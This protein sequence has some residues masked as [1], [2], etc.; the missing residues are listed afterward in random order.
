MGAETNDRRL[1]S[2]LIQLFCTALLHGSVAAQSPPGRLQSNTSAQIEVLVTS[3]ADGIYGESIQ[4]LPLINRSAIEMLA[5]SRRDIFTMSNPD[6][7]AATRW[8]YRMHVRPQDKED[9]IVAL[10]SLQGES[11]DVSTK[12]LAWGTGEIEKI[13]V[14][15]DQPMTSILLQPLPLGVLEIVTKIAAVVPPPGFTKNHIAVLTTD[16]FFRS[17]DDGQTWGTVDDNGLSGATKY[18][19]AL[20]FPATYILAHS[21]GLSLR[22]VQG[23]SWSNLPYFLGRAQK[24]VY[25]DRL[26]RIFVPDGQRLLSS[27]NNAAS[28]SVLDSGKAWIP[29]LKVF[30]DDSYKNIYGS[31]GFSCWEFPGGTGPA[32]HVDLQLKTKFWDEHPTDQ[33]INS[34]GGDNHVYAGTRFGGYR[35]RPDTSWENLTQGIKSLTINGFIQLRSGK[36]VVS[37]NLGLSS[38]LSK[39]DSVFLHA[40]PAKYLADMPV[41]TDKDDRIYT[42]GLRWDPSLSNSLRLNYT[43][44]DAGVTFNPDTAGLAAMGNGTAPY[45]SVTSNGTQWY[46]GYGFNS[47][48]YSK[49]SGNSWKTDI[50]GIGLRPSFRP[51]SLG[52]AGDR[53]YFAASDAVTGKGLVWSRSTFESLWAED[54]LGLGQGNVYSFTSMRNGLAL[55]GTFNAGLWRYRYGS[56]KRTSQGGSN[57]AAATLGSWKKLPSPPGLENACVF[58]V[59]V[60]SSGAIIA[61]FTVYTG[62]GFVARGV[63]ATQDTGITWTNAVLDSIGVRQLVSYGTTT[64]VST[65][66]RGLWVIER[67][68]ATSASTSAAQPL[69]FSLVQNYPNPF[70]ASTVI[71]YHVPGTRVAL[72]RLTVYDLL[73]R[74]VKTLVNETK[75]PGAYTVQFDASGLTSGAYFYRLQSGGAVQMKKALLI[76]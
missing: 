42:L 4:S 69:E 36:Q 25:V 16:R 68:T 52:S 35:L 38:R 56:F 15:R 5:A 19:V 74:E 39:V 30:G 47:L 24:Q 13:E 72:V 37:N 76:K 20:H 40:W 27:T 71:G 29:D 64:Y 14:I 9:R 41:F 50:D 44:N 43:S 48:L 49:T 18:S 46:A 59:S 66:N 26:N 21:N 23:T 7:V 54:T 55:A 58:A 31:D 75:N 1:K 70:N 28:W 10:S 45:Y 8:R 12:Y 57:T 17:T 22:D 60:D 2:V 62:T 3:R 67:G 73:G 51:T 32:L 65:I 34:I 11:G 53:Y 33:V 61:A 63:Y 6:S